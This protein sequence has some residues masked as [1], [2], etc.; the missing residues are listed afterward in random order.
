MRQLIGG[1]ALVALAATAAA[2][3]TKHA[4]T[5]LLI[6]VSGRV[7]R[8]QC[9]PADGTVPQPG[10]ICAELRRSPNLL[11]GG[12]AIDHSCPANDRAWFRIAG[13][14]RGRRVDAMFPPSSCAWVPGQGDGAGIWTYLM[15]GA[16]N[17]EPESTFASLRV[18]A[19]RTA[20]GS[21]NLRLEARKLARQR[22]AALAAGT[23][24][25]KRGSPP[26]TLTLAVLRAQLRYAS[27]HGPEIAHALLYSTTERR[28]DRATGVAGPPGFDPPV[29]VV[30]NRYAYRDWRGRKHVAAGCWWAQYDARTLDLGADGGSDCLDVRSLGPPVKLL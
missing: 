25:V 2:C 23:L 10:R 6:D 8:L 15:H 21:E 19:S 3:G 5:R 26:D 11:V 27:A 12:T 13:T 17:G 24:R 4:S 22:R 29:Y 18:T 28:V 16:G 14:Y 7:Y 30:V 9:G 1:A 20:G